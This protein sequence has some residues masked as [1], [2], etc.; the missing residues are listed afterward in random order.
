MT[1]NYGT[2]HTAISIAATT[3]S[4]LLASNIAPILGISI[5]PLVVASVVGIASC[6]WW[7]YRET[8]GPGTLFYA[9]NKYGIGKHSKKASLD[10]RLDWMLPIAAVVVNLAVIILL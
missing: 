6:S 5:D 8:K 7:I 10:R 3:G 1:N 2:T 9:P 4:F